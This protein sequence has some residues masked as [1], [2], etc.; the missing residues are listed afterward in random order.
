[1]QQV[2]TLIE[3]SS[4]F[5]LETKLRPPSAR[6]EAVARNR[7]FEQLEAADGGSLTLVA[8]PAGYGKTTLLGM[9]RDVEADRR[10]VAWLTLDEG[11]NDPAVLWSYVLE[12]LTRASVPFDLP[13]TPEP[14][15][16]ARLVDVLLPRIVNRLEDHGPCALVLD[17]FHRLSSGPARESVKWF[18]EHAPPTFQVVVS[19]RSEPTLPL[20]ALRVQGKLVELRAQDLRFTASEANAFMNGG[21]EIG[22]TPRE[23]DLLVERTE[24]WPAGL[25]LAALSLRGVSDRSAFVRSY[26]GANHF[27]VDFLVDEVLDAYDPATQALMIRASI[28]DRMCGR[29]CD[30]VLDQNGS[31]A[32]LADLARTNLFLVPLDDRGEWFRFHHLF[33]ELLRVELEHREPGRA[34]ALHS[35]AYAWHRDHGS[36][37]DA[38]KHALEAGAFDEAAKLIAAVWPDYSTAG[39]HAS[40]LAWLERFPLD[41][42]HEHQPLLLV[43][44][45]VS[46]LCARRDDAEAAIAAVEEAGEPTPGPLPDGFSSIDASL[47]TLRGTIPWDDVGEAL[48]NARLAAELEGAESSWWPV[49]C[50][51]LGRALYLRGATDDADRWFAQAVDAAAAS[52]RWT[53]S[54]SALA[55]RSIIAGEQ[56]RRD[57]QELLSDQAVRLAQERGVEDIPAEV[58]IASGLSGASGGRIEQALLLLERVVVDLRSCGQPIELAYA[59]I[60]QASVLRTVGDKVAFAGSIAEARATVD[61]CPDPGVLCERLTALERPQKT[62]QP[63]AEKEL[64]A[65][66]LVILRGLS[67]PLSA[68]DIGRELFVSHNTV[69]S[70]ARSIYRKLGVNSRSAAVRQ[71]RELGLI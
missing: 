57:E 54:L 30:A 67:G 17:D 11:D 64:S 3:S 61:S 59:L 14:I 1:M 45:W 12:A 21:L 43:Q 69:N 24:G 35:R 31:G 23:I 66:E 33:A 28:L 42:L 34:Q 68:R 26:G 56:G 51:A 71:G 16:R 6:A 60:C 41:V 25:Y 22:L 47:A 63:S 7:L 46:S 18:V 27:V 9:W 65:R 13:L 58:S 70:H 32:R 4:P 29:L 15:D 50:A 5:L 10:P 19:S 62:R 44:A 8:A 38:I 36:P 37:D 2:E 52:Q 55:Y 53:W 39:R 40:V 48:E 49:I 20:A